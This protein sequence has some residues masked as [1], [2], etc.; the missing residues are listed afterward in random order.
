MTISAE[1][2][3]QVRWHY[4]YVKSLSRSSFRILILL[5]V[6][7]RHTTLIRYSHQ[8]NKMRQQRS[9]KAVKARPGQEFRARWMLNKSDDSNHS[10]GQ[11]PTFLRFE[12]RSNLLKPQAGQQFRAV[13]DLA[14]ENNVTVVAGADPSVGVSGGW[15][16]VRN[17]PR[18]DGILIDPQTGWR[19]Q[20]DFTCSGTWR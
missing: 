10:R 15:V 9:K 7:S 18:L 8:S 17:V 6:T 4:G 5:V 3:V 20:R 12:T 14:R 2:R 19:S 11:C 1:V 16:M 13:Y